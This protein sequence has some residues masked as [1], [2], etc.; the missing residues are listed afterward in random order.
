MDEIPPIEEGR[1][2]RFIAAK[3]VLDVFVGAAIVAVLSPILLL[4]AAAIKIFDPG[5]L[6]F[7]QIRG[8]WHGRPFRVYKFRTMRAGRTPDPKELVPLD[9]PEITSLGRL[10]RRTKIDEWPQLLNVLRGDMSLIGPRPTLLDQIEAY[11]DFQRLRL[12]VRPGCT[13]LAQIHGGAS[14]SWPERI[15]YDVY[16]VAR[17]SLRIDLWV[18]LMTPWNILR[19][20][21]RVARPFAESACAARM[22][23]KQ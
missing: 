8:G 3:R 20:E 15:R 14:I 18:I 10:L 22:P 2:R 23:R 5:P 17:A 4:T 19:G 13:G 6:L 11:D 21:D 16:Y 7:S 12:R 1:L 9:H